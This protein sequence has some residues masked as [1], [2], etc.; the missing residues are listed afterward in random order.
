MAS[1]LLFTILVK[2]NENGDMGHAFYSKDYPDS[3]MQPVL[4][5]HTDGTCEGDVDEDGD[6][7]GSDLAWMAADY[8]RESCGGPILCPG[9]IDGD[10][11][12][13]LWDLVLFAHGFGRADCP[14]GS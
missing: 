14:D 4:I 11:T 8:N 5:V 7:D 12:V 3:T 1:E 2:E 13:G 9:D 6:I 10:L